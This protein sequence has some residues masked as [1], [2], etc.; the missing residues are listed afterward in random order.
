MISHPGVGEGARKGQG[1]E[2]GRAGT[3][4]GS[5][6]PRAWLG[7]GRPCLSWAQL[8]ARSP[9]SVPP[10]TLLGS[11]SVM[12]ALAGTSRG[13]ELSPLRPPFLLGKCHW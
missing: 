13:H 2:A 9:N 12:A 3:L 10:L 7:S 1:Q 6:V 8:R 11:H 4:E 5:A